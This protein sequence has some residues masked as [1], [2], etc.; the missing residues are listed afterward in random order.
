[1]NILSRCKRSEQDS[2]KIDCISFVT[3]CC[4]LLGYALVSI[5]AANYNR[6]LY[7]DGSY[8]LVRM[9]E[10][11][12][13][14]LFDPARTTVQIMRQFPVVV[15]QHWSD[16]NL[17][18]LGQAFSLSMLL[19]PVVLCAACWPILPTGQKSWIF[20]PILHLLAGVS[21]SRFAAIA[22]G[23]I[24]ASYF[25]PLLFFLLFRTRGT[26][27]QLLFF[28]LLLPAF[29]LHETVIVLTPIWALSCV[30]RIRGEQE[31]PSR[32]FLSVSAAMIVLIAAHELYWIVFPRFAEDRAVYFSSLVSA[33][34]LISDDR[35]N[36][37]LI[38]G[39]V[40]LAA[41]I[42]LACINLNAAA[43]MKRWSMTLA[44]AFLFYAM[45]ATWLAWYS[46]LGFAPN[47]QLQA[48]NH[49]VFISTILAALA[50]MVTTRG[51]SP[52]RWVGAP[53]ILILAA[54]SVAQLVWDIAA[55]DRWRSYVDDV[56]ERMAGSVGFIYYEQSFYSGDPA[57]DINWRLMTA[58]YAMPTLSI[59]LNTG[60]PVASLVSAPKNTA[61]QAFDP[62]KPDLLP[63]IRG[64]NYTP[65]VLAITR[66]GRDQARR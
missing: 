65:F 44:I 3:C 30:L 8:Y 5:Y 13:F 24:A 37:P 52:N 50:A 21:A 49:A 33:K 14:L 9:A 64:I 55:T 26:H 25:W 6:G 4:I 11:Q 53:T 61:W 62:S 34:F 19:L 38:N 63:R 41:L 43:G 22:E 45:A 17:A 42:A 1:M 56:R 47:A 57:K 7:A 2:A 60:D 10:T 39:A 36:L 48:R 32:I 51:L 16:L 40:A 46:D 58:G 20:F 59:A 31:H 28:G 27:G 18:Q 54:L 12:S 35:V 66:T 29:F 23:A 15:L